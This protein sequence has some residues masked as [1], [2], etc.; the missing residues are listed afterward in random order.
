[1]AEMFLAIWDMMNTVGFTV[2]DTHISY[3]DIFEFGIYGTLF[4]IFIVW[5]IGGND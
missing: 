4:V 3:A 5:L 1:M 2:N